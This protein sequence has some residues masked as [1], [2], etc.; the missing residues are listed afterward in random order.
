MD[1]D[2]GSG[3][4]VKGHRRRNSPKL[5]AWTLRWC[6]AFIVSFLRALLGKMRG[7]K[8]RGVLW[9]EPGLC[10]NIRPVMSGVCR[11]RPFK[12]ETPPHLLGGLAF[13]SSF[14]QGILYLEVLWFFFPLL[15]SG[16]FHPERVGTK[17]SCAYITVSCLLIFLN[18]NGLM[19][20]PTGS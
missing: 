8:C 12:I 20:L 7:C 19:L 14:A 16:A 2:F 18:E 6:H 11:S 4:D 13:Q 1:A 5:L 10:L 17:V 9:V 3:L 15:G